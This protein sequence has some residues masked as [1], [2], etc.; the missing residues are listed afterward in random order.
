[1]K[2]VK[3]KSPQHITFID[4]KKKKF[5]MKRETNTFTYISKHMSYGVGNY[6]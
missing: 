5:K 3:R 1:M 6:F 2:L 4:I